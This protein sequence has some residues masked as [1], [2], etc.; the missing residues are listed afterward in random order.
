MVAR[1]RTGW[2]EDPKLTTVA[3]GT[4]SKCSTSSCCCRGYLKGKNNCV[5][6]RREG[7]PM[8]LW[9]AG[10]RRS[11]AAGWWSRGSAVRERGEKREGEEACRFFLN[12]TRSNVHLNPNPSYIFYLFTCLFIYLFPWIHLL[13]R[14][15]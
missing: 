11:W 7:R 1:D 6:G 3:G 10:F 9:E 8:V 4:C 5:T 2:R 15:N 13:A 12:G 14:P